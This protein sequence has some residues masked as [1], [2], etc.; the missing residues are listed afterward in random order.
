MH[1]GVMHGAAR[2]PAVDEARQQ[3][4]QQ[5]HLAQQ[6][7]AAQAPQPRVPPAL[8]LLLCRPLNHSVRYL[9]KPVVDEE[10]QRV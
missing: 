2:W 8:L 3:V 7:L 6:R 5:R 10:Q 9:S 4:L 1:D